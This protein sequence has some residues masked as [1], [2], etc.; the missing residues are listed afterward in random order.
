M[1]PRPLE[2]DRGP[3]RAQNAVA[4]FRHLQPRR[5]LGGDALQLAAALELRHEFAQVGIR[6]VG[7]SALEQHQS[8]G[9]R[10]GEVEQRL[11]AAAHRVRALGRGDREREGGRAKPAEDR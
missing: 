4:D 9:E 5:H 1:S 3:A 6:H 7:L 2:Q 8:L 11:V 10:L